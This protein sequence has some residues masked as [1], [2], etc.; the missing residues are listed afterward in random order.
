MIRASAS[1]HSAIIDR[2]FKANTNDEIADNGAG[3]GFVFGPPIASWRE[4]DLGDTRI[5]F[6]VDGNPSAETFLQEGPCPPLLS[7]VQA[8]RMLGGRSIDISARQCI[9]TRGN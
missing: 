1:H 7:L 5:D 9:S 3:I 6:H 4:L 2:V 8:T